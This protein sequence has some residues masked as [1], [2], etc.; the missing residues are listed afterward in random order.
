[1]K[2]IYLCVSM[3]VIILFIGLDSQQ[4]KEKR[5]ELQYEAA[6]IVKLVPVRV[7]D[8]NGRPVKGL[9]KEDFILYDND[10]LK[11]I[12][13]FEVHETGITATATADPG[14]KIQPHTNRKYFILLDIQGSDANGMANAKEAA[15]EFLQTKIKQGDEVGI[16]SFAPMTGL[17]IQQ[18][19]TS[20]PDKIEKGIKRAKEVPPT[21]GFRSGENLDNEE[22]ESIAKRMGGS[23][24]GKG[25]T[26]IQG[27][28]EAG[29]SISP[30]RARR[31]MRVT[32]L[33]E[34]ARKFSD[35][36]LSMSDL[37]NAMKYIPGSKNVVY[38]SSREPG[39]KVARQFAEANAP[40]YA[41]NTKD[42][43]TQG[44]YTKVKKK[45]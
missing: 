32:G 29:A 8:A 15:L 28:S 9:K 12:T 33:V 30:F 38:F 18:Y 34:Y 27:I 25:M 14:T 43:I 19:L 7:L 10:E 26:S 13:E 6:A 44:V 39:K 40:V 11:I 16:L 17:T 3:A 24:G 41:V 5:Q 42:W 4:Q 1:M 2:R 37:A 22:E 35:F 23:E 20:D 31:P 36:N 21:P 45:Q